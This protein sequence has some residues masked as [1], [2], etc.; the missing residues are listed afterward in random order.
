MG[1]QG[2]RRV[3]APGSGS[4]RGSAPVA[5]TQR[6]VR[7]AGCRRPARPRGRPRS[8]AAT[9]DAAAQ[10][11]VVLGVPLLGV[12]DGVVELGLAGEVALRQRRPLVGQLVL[13]GE[14]GDRPVVP[15]LA[16]RLGGLGAGQA[17]A[18]DDDAAGGASAMACLLVAGRASAKNSCRDRGSSRSSA[19]QRRGHGASAPRPARRAASC[20]CARPRSPHRRR[21]GRGAPRASR[22]PAWSA[23][24]APAGGRRSGRPPGPAWTGRGSARRAGSRRG[25]RRERQQVVLADRAQ[26][27][28]PGQR[29]ARRSPRRWGR[30]S[31]RTRRS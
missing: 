5:S 12:D 24:P 8:I 28:R 7:A 27:D 29:P 21:G 25:R 19:E 16:Q 6:A 18:D 26:R 23:A 1:A 22:R 15:L 31:G 10:V 14:Q 13:G 20:R 17:A 3:S 4:V 11:D 30:W 9:V 2:Q